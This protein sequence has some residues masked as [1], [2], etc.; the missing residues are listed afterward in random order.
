MLFRKIPT[1]IQYSMYSIHVSSV[2]TLPVH[3]VRY[4]MFSPRP[5]LPKISTGILEQSMGLRER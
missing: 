3:M 5:T 2:T 4:F 1:R